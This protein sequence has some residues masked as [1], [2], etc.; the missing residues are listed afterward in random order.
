[1]EEIGFSPV[2]SVFDRPRA[3]AMELPAEIDVQIVVDNVKDFAGDD[4]VL[5]IA[6]LCFPERMNT[7]FQYSSV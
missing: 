2:P 6:E 5:R 3:N 7:K 1:M 4:F